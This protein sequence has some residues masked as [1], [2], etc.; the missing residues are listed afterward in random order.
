MSSWI[1]ALPFACVIIALALLPSVLPHLWESPGRRLAVLMLPCAAAIWAMGD[2][3]PHVLT[4]SLT[5]YV[6]FMAL[7]VSLFGVAGGIVV[8][9]GLKRGPLGNVLW[10]TLGALL[11]SFVGTTGAS[12]LL[13]RPFVRA[14]AQRRYSAHTVVFFIFIV[15]NVGGMLTP[16]GDPPLFL[17]Y[18]KGVPFAW[19]LRLTPAWLLSL[20]MLLPLFYALDTWRYRQEPLSAELPREP[21]HI[22]G[23]HNLLFFAL[24]VLVVACAPWLQ[25][26]ALSQAALMLAVLALSYATTHAKIYRHNGVTLAPMVEVATV[27]LAVFITMPDALATLT[28]AAPHFGPLGQETFFWLTGGLSA[29]LDN[30][31][32]YVTMATLA[33]SQL[34]LTG[35]SLA[36]LAADARGCDLLMAIATGAVTMGAMTYIG[37]GPNLMVRAVAQEAKLQVPSF[38]GYVAWSVA[39]LLPVLVLMRLALH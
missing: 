22:E 15:A 16:L 17:G 13:I 30:A 18:L 39:T 26:H 31:P 4:E 33:Q 38:M 24:L 8:Q 25:L 14:Q 27:F 34:Q 11:A 3:A 6:A 21:L 10:L 35:A 36:P 20:G 32:C 7:L 28:E 29:V 9:G 5:D 37:N 2:R 19:T 23:G 12:M 1:T